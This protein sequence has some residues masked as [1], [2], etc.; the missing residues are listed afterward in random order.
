MLKAAS[1]S[2]SFECSSAL[3]SSHLT[4]SPFVLQQFT[5]VCCP[6]NYMHS[7]ESTIYS[8]LCPNVGPTSL[9]LARHWDII[10]FIDGVALM[11]CG[12][13][14]NPTD[15]RFADIREGVSPLEHTITQPVTV[16]LH[17][18]H[19]ITLCFSFINPLNAEIFYIN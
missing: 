7:S 14:S 3:S 9:T 5:S 2:M 6:Y 15:H 11:H 19:L 4:I 10:G 8:Q 13:G 12:F 1:S 16:H 18:L 17:P